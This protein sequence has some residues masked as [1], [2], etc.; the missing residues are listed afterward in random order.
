MRPDPARSRAGGSGAARPGRRVLKAR[1]GRLANSAVL[2][3]LLF[4]TLYPFA[5]MVQKSVQSDAQMA[6]DFWGLERPLQW[7]YYSGAWGKVAPYILNSVK[8]SV[9]TVAGVVF[10]ASLSA[11]CFARYRFRGKE[12]V[13]YAV[14]SLLMIPEIL[15]LVTRYLLVDRLGLIDTHWALILPGMAMLQVFAIFILR[16]FFAGLPEELFEAARLDGA[17]EWT[18]YL[19]L[20]LPMSRPVLGTVAILVLLVVWNDFI[21]PLVTLPTRADLLTIPVGLAHLESVDLPP[22]IGRQMAG[23][24]IASLPLLAL[25]AVAMRTFIKG[26]TAGA[27]KG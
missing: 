17:S 3:I 10:L 27:I 18:I 1:L 22:P 25:F 2:G 23:Y 15:T 12:L 4:L 6:H 8:V 26:F 9:V 5:F 7:S 14:I 19:R 11:F 16:G 13:Y 24:T 21:W 20:A